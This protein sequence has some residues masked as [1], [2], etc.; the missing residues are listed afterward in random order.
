MRNCEEGKGREGKGREGKGKE[1]Q[2]RTDRSGYS[3]MNGSI[4]I[5]IQLKGCDRVNRIHL[6]QK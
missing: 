1:G 6:T 5:D 4:N 2:E 3:G